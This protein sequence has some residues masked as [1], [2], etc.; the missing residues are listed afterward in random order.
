MRISATKCCLYMYDFYR[1][2]GREIDL[3]LQ[4]GYFFEVIMNSTKSLII[5]D[6]LSTDK[7]IKILRSQDLDEAR[8]LVASIFCEHGLSIK[9]NKS[10]NYSHDHVEIGAIGLSYM[11]Y[12]A[13]VAVTP[14][15][16][17]SFYLVQLPVAGHDRI[18]I[19][20]HEYESDKD[21]AT[22][23]SPQ[24]P[25]D[26]NWSHDCHKLVVKINKE[27]LERHASNIFGRT[28]NNPLKFSSVMDL[29]QPAGVAWSSS[30]QSLYLEIQRSPRLFDSALIR[31]QLEQTLMSTLLTWHSHELSDYLHDGTPSILPWHL[32]RAVEFIQECPE[33]I[34]TMETL[35]EITGVHVRTLFCGFS[36]F[37]GISPMRYLRDVRLERVYQDLL[38]PSQPRS[39]TDIATR[40]GFYQLGRMAQIYKTRYGE[41]PRD[42]LLR[43]SYK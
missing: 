19:N 4:K 17:G 31:S 32:K 42:T 22:V 21:L 39:V 3:K 14:G 33:Q 30:V 8:S 36:K 12:G 1:L 15:K 29:Q 5:L 26:M 11:G 18:S 20:G 35:S 9:R 27:S 37:L 16:L 38:D 40:W 28:V 25:L 43:A 24:E 10:I 2:I 41:S 7:D 34:I 6:S 13:D 23:H